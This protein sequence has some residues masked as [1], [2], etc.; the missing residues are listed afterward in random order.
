MAQDWLEYIV[1]G[2]V[3]ALC[4]AFVIRKARA[5]FSAS[6]ASPCCG[7]SGCDEKAAAELPKRGTPASQGA[8]AD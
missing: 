3:L 2:V 7:C 8:S 5:R 4:L 6:G 1:L